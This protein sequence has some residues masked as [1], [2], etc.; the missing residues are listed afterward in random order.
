MLRC[1]YQELRKNFY[2][3]YV[4]LPVVSILALCLAGTGEIDA[5]GNEITIFS[6]ILQGREAAA[7]QIEKSALYL[8]MQGMGTWL[9]L[10]LPLLLTFGYV[11][12]I[13][14]ERQN[15]QVMF[16]LL[17]SGNFRYCIAKVVSGAL[18]GG[19]ILVVSYALFGILMAAFFP[20]FS[21]YP[22]ED[23]SFYLE[24]YF[25]NNIG[26]Y[27][28]KRLAGV[29]FF[30]VSASAF[31][32]GVAIFFRDKYMLLCLP[33]LLNYMYRQI[34]MK[35]IIS[36]TMEG[37]SV[38]WIET[39]YPDTMIHISL[40]RYWFT[41]VLLLLILYMGLILLFY[42]SVKRGICRE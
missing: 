30:G 39:F 2:L 4:I 33:F 18:F 10:F 31:G 22:L 32:I 34:L 13:S 38:K 36:R 24:F 15:G 21:S 8:W 35:W 11:A 27:I 37:G 9:T 5:N 29:F 25:D 7:G 3:P 28:F 17:R 40:D 14:E 1:I 20:A 19:I 16:Q 12:L 26:I 6:L 41:S 23:Q 42:V